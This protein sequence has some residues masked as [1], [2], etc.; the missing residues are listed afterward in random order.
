MISEL[1]GTP[2]QTLTGFVKDWLKLLSEGRFDEACALLDRPDD[3]GRVWTPELIRELV[4]DT[5]NPQTLFYRNHPE[6]PRFTDPYALTEERRYQSFGEFNDT[7]G[8]WLDYPVPMNGEWSDL[9]AQFEFHVTANGYAAILNDL[10][11]M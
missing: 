8:Y 7:T 2:R 9:T 1:A 5:Y 4:A 6:G 10:H 3:H 11:I